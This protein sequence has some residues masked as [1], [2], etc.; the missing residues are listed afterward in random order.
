MRDEHM[1]GKAAIDGD[2]E[3]T[4]RSTQIL[5]ASAARRASAAADPGID[6]DL[7][8]NDRSVGFTSRGFDHAGDLVA[9][10]ER[11]RAILGDVE[12]LLATE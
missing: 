5:L 10:R 12:P 3:M 9:E 11:Q 1:R 6:R 4:G 8:A 2:A 7:A